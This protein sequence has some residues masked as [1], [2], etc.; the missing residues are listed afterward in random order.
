MSYHLF[1]FDFDGTLADSADWVM[2]TF[3]DLAGEH[4]FRRVTDEELRMLRGRSNREIVKYLG[5]PAWK[6][7]AIAAARRRIARDIHQIKLFAGVP[8]MLGALKARGALTAIV[9]S[10]S[11]E[12]V[13]SVLGPE[14]A[15]NVHLFDCGASLFG[16]ARKLRNVIARSK[17]PA[18]RAI[19]IGDETRDI[20]AA[21]EV[22]VA[23]GA[24][25]WG[26]ATKEILIA[27]RPSMLLR[28]TDDIVALAAPI[29][30]S[31]D[32]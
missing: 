4:G 15:R 26:Y 12:N 29:P 21:Q 10:N 23:S 31:I 8:D 1:I 3:N 5:V 27:H 28:T 13:R 22:G 30:A 32:E 18:D 24:V 9:T 11:E 17:I 25:T 7:P 14:N 20:E 19:C 6:L 2:R 16:K